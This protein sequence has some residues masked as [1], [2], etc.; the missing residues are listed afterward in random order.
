VLQG[1]T[2]DMTEEVIED[3]ELFAGLQTFWTFSEWSDAMVCAGFQPAAFDP[4]LLD[5]VWRIEQEADEDDWD[6]YPSKETIR[7]TFFSK[8]PIERNP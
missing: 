1:V 8:P 7:Q 3:Y 2:T 6:W 5:E 4:V